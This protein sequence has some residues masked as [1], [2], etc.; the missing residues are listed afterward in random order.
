ML[1]VSMNVDYLSH[2][3]IRIEFDCVLVK[4]YR[5]QKL[6]SHVLLVS[7]RKRF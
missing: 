7:E 3:E 6:T 2:R 1:T 5:R 4:R